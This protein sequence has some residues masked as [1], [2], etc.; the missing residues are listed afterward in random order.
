M[1]RR[2][3]LVIGK[4]LVALCVA[5]TAVGI[6]L[7]ATARNMPIH[8]NEPRATELMNLYTQHYLDWTAE[9]R[10][11]IEQE[12]ISLRTSKW[13][14]YRAG[15]GMCLVAPL[16]LGAMVRFRLWD[17]RNLLRATTPRTRLRLLAIESIAW[18]AL[19]P[20]LL[21]ES[22]DEYTQ[23]DLTPTID[24][25]HGAL[26]FAGPPFFLVMW[27]AMLLVGRFVILRRVLL[28]ANLWCW[29]SEWPRRS[30]FWIVTYGLLGGALLILIAGSA[31]ALASPWPL[32]SLLVGLYVISSTR[33]ALLNRGRS[34]APTGE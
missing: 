27:I 20:A 5:A 28:P 4:S 31:M 17:V 19:L 23:D 21:F 3:G 11:P 24:T 29:D 6:A 32:P 13:I 22:D 8:T 1:N 34:A 18:W 15:L 7:L 26:A 25:G 16:L 10:A 2:A 9:Q 12:V 33:A 14:L 30:M